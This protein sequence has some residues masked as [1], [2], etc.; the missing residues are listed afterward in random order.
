MLGIGYPGIL[1]VKSAKQGDRWSWV[2]EAARSPQKKIKKIKKIT[3][4]NFPSSSFYYGHLFL[5]FLAPGL[6]Q[7]CNIY[8]KSKRNPYRRYMVK[9]KVL[10]NIAT[11]IQ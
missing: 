10:T 6:M 1:A 11:N 8:F 2:S 4:S 3:R 5:S 9:V 7:P